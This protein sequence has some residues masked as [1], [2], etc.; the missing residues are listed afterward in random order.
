MANGIYWETGMVWVGPCYLM[1]IN[2]KV[3]IER[4]YAMAKDNIFLRMVQ[5]TRG[6]GVKVSSTV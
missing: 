1:G 4:A 3:N 5:D 6:N 2:M